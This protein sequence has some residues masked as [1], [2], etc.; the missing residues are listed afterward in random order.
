MLIRRPNVSCTGTQHGCVIHFPRRIKSQPTA[1]QDR[2]DS[3]HDLRSI[4]IRAGQF[5]D[6]LSDGTRG[7]CRQ[8]V[9]KRIAIGVAVFLHEPSEGQRQENT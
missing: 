2:V 5:R 6:S 8:Y 3:M 1:S 4:E 7:P 9:E